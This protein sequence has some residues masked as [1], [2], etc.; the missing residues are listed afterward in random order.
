MVHG[1]ER[2][3]LYCKEEPC[4]ISGEKLVESSE[5]YALSHGYSRADYRGNVRDAASDRGVG[6]SAIQWRCHQFS[7]ATV[8]L[9]ARCNVFVVVFVLRH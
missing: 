6:K 1:V 4:Q 3:S 9:G 5:R 2:S 8:E 7:C